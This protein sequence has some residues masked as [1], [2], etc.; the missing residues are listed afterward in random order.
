M[1]PEGNEEN[2]EYWLARCVERKHKLTSPRCDDDGFEYPTG[3]VVVVGT[4]LAKILST[5]N[6]LGAYED[7]EPNKK[8]IQY[9]YLILATNIKLSKYKGKPTNKVLWK[10]SM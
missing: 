4:W 5:R 10:I 3:S 1:A 9:S 6:G 8:F 7:Y 2:I